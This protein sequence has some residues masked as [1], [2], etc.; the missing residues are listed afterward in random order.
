MG[1][2]TKHF[3]IPKS[4][5]VFGKHCNEWCK[6]DS[7]NV[8]IKSLYIYRII[9]LFLRSIKKLQNY[10]RKLYSLPPNLMRATVRCVIKVHNKFMSLCVQ[11]Q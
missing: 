3:Q 4:W 7:S 2:E 9:L 1:N 6:L 11:C 5:W 8:K 10:I